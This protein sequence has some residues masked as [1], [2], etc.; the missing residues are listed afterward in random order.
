MYSEFA[1]RRLVILNHFALWGK[2]KVKVQ[3]QGQI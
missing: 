1:G 2:F 3:F